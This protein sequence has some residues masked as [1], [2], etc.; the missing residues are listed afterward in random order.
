M[1]PF[2]PLVEALLMWTVVVPLAVALPLA[3]IGWWRTKTAPPERLQSWALA[4]LFGAFL[5]CFLGIR[6]R[7]TFPPGPATDW[8]FYLA[9]LGA[10]AEVALGAIRARLPAVLLRAGV[11]GAGVV[12]CVAPIWPQAE[13]YAVSA[14]QGMV[15]GAVLLLVLGSTV[16]TA[17]RTTSPVLPL[18]FLVVS[19]GAA[20]V[21]ANTGS[22]TLAQL[23]GSLGAG[24][25]PFFVVSYLSNG[26]DLRTPLAYL[27]LTVG[28]VSLQAWLYSDTPAGSLLLL[29]AA[30]LLTSTLSWDWLRERGEWIAVTVCLVVTALLVGGGLLL[31]TLPS[32]TG[33][34][35]PDSPSGSGSYRP[36]E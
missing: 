20:G 18:S 19:V 7:P 4:S 17:G 12:A 13:T 25:G 35:P 36:Y 6:G 34:S 9:V 32:P 5:A 23:A 27:V 31:T 11:V 1:T 29:G 30:V 24:L 3:L 8:L 14:A 33:E 22:L 26:V 28:F 15:F 21:F 10:A 2:S 16:W